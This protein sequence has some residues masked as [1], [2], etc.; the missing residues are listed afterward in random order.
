MGIDDYSW[1]R[2]ALRVGATPTAPESSASAWTEA[3]RIAG[4]CEVRHPARSV[5]KAAELVVF[6]NGA[7]SSGGSFRLGRADA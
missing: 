4:T 2:R 3:Q 7:E 5:V 6:D 1:H